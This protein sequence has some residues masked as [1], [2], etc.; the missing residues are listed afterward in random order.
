MPHGLRSKL[1]EGASAHL[2][3][4][5]QMLQGSRQ[6]AEQTD[7]NVAMLA[8]ADVLAMESRLHKT[9]EK[10]EQARDS[11][12]EAEPCSCVDT[13]EDAARLLR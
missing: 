10:L 9:L 12:G 2:R 8:I 11:L 6:Q 1:A 5:L 13:M 7:S 3:N 4:A